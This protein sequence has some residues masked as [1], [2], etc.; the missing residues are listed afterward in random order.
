MSTMI[1][2]LK[3]ESMKLRRNWAL[4]LAIVCPAIVLI[5]GVVMALYSL[6]RSGQNRMSYESWTGFM[7]LLWAGMILTFFVAISAAQLA[8]FEH[9]NHQW[10]HLNALPLPRW[11]TYLAKQTVLSGLILA[12]HLLLA[13]GILVSGFLIH[14]LHGGGAFGQPPWMLLL[15]GTGLC[16]GASLFMQAIQHW[17]AMRFPNLALSIGSALLGLVGGIALSGDAK[18]RWYPWVMPGQ[19][20][21]EWFPN[22][23]KDPRPGTVLL[24]SLA[25]CAFITMLACL[26]A[27]RRETP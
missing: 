21:T 19:A 18:G 12:A 16:F 17:I 27:N 1:A 8:G 22:M 13:A 14:F 11:A 6:D 9:H 26:D 15:G 25:G 10:K 7:L 4:G 23:Q 24:I 2:L 20:L 5:F 3:A